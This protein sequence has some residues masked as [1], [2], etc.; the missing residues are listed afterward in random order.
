MYIKPS[1]RLHRV[2]KAAALYT[3][4][5]TL[6]TS[7]PSPLFSSRYRSVFDE[8]RRAEYFDQFYSVLF[9]QRFLLI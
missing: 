4:D 3:R 8:P 1:I 5:G 2:F 9:H 6:P 7:I